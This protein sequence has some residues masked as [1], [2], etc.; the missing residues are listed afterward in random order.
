MAVYSKKILSGGSGNGRAIEVEKT[1]TLGTTIHTAVSGT[2]SFDEIWLWAFNTHTADVLLTIEW[3][4]VT[5]PDDLMEVTI[6]FNEGWF[7]IVP[8]FLLQNAKLVTAFSAT[9][10]VIMINGYVNGIV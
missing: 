2:S 5:T 7:Q 1:V 8:G 6:P 3:G 10:N 9:N 4:G